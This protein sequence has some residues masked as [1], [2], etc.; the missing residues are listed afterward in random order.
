MVGVAA[1][2]AVEI[3]NES[4]LASIESV[5]DEAS[6]QA[7]LVV[8]SASADEHGFRQEILHRVREVEGVR[9]AAPV[10]LASTLLAQEAGNWRL[11]VTISGRRTTVNELL[12]YGVDPEID[13]LARDYKISSGRFLEKR[14]RNLS[15]VLVEEYAHE[16]EIEVGEEVKIL[17]PGGETSLK[18]VGLIA[19]KGPGRMNNGSVGFVPLKTAQ[20]IFARGGKIDQIDVVATP[21]V[22]GSSQKLAELKARLEEQLGE[23]F[24]ILYPAAR[25]QVI[26][27]SLESYQF[28]LSFFSA[29]ALFVG[30]F[31]VYNTF[32]MT[33][34]ERTR[35]IGLLRSLGL[36]KGQVAGLILQEALLLGSIGS[37]LG[38]G[39]GVAL[40]QGL[41][42]LLSEM[43]ATEARELVVPPSGVLAGL[44]VGSAVTLI[45]ALFPSYQASR[46]SPLEAIRL[47]AAS[48]SGWLM[49]RGWLL[50]LVLSALSLAGFYFPLPEELAY[51]IGY[52]SIFALLA[53][54]TLT[55]SL[56]LGPLCRAFFSLAGFLYGN[57]GRLGARNVE[58]SRGRTLLTVAALMVSV[59]MI[60]GNG[61]MTT[62]LRADLHT[63]VETSIGG[64]L[65]VRSP[66]PMRFDLGGRF[67]AI[68]GVAAVSP[69]Q[70]FPVKQVVKGEGGKDEKEAMSFAAI[71]PESYLK[72]ADFMFSSEKG[73]EEAMINRLKKGEA[74]FISGLLA[75]K[76]KLKRG[77]TIRLE[78]RRGE[79]DFEVAGVV[80]D[81]TSNGYAITG[82]LHDARRYFGQNKADVF[83]IKLAPGASY[84]TV[85]ERIKER[86]GQ[87][88]HL[89]VE[90]SQEFKERIIQVANQSFV[91][92]DALVAI[93]MIVAALGVLNTLLMNVIERQRE[94]GGLRSLGMTKGQVG[95]MILAEAGSMGG[96]GAAVGMT[97]GLFLSTVFVQAMNELSGYSVEY[98]LPGR[99]I[100]F[101]LLICF[102]VSQVAAFYPAWKAAGVNIVE[103]IQHE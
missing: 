63:W 47:R 79:H 4:L 100:V 82:T 61:A 33:V 41:V 8:E 102:V 60:V 77:D 73:Q 78:T 24:S 85:A 71:E 57:E 46:I 72:V 80:V 81:F 90:T 53:G 3:S 40:A 7:H 67:A 51:P 27:Q 58:R 92:F 69:A 37:A 101:S 39:A 26:S 30:A 52:A 31:L 35:E 32:A 15:I 94:I 2:L 34:V 48:E 91:L 28:G 23:D 74:V 38:V 75:D 65:Q 83:I 49:R 59:T 17:T 68:E 62:S 98:V 36:T 56:F 44:S 84:E 9:I 11:E 6:G 66:I 42:R 95:K 5:F 20:E 87:R 45:A 13:P 103:A 76:Y 12:V 99:H 25:S 1:I 86:Y 43:V 89:R 16:R 70:F 22:G 88:R 10:L 14:E 50:G 96:I 64:D 55:L 18:V 19:K 93:S 29:M 54:A 21:E 97:L